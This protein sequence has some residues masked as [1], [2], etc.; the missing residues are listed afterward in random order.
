MEEEREDCEEWLTRMDQEQNIVTMVIMKSQG[1][2]HQMSGCGEIMSLGLI[3]ELQVGVTKISL[4]AQ[5][6]CTGSVA[7][8]RCVTC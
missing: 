3:L 1:P 6:T 4:W 5:L 2:Y 7:R 8:H